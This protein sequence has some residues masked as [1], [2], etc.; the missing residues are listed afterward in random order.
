MLFRTKIYRRK[1]GKTGGNSLKSEVGF[2]P[3]RFFPATLGSE[4][5]RKRRRKSRRKTLIT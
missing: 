1:E 4:E 3:F 2:L 5:K